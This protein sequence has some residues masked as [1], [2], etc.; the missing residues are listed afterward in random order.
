MTKYDEI[1]TICCNPTD[2]TIALIQGVDTDLGLWRQ[3]LLDVL[4]LEHR[5]RRDVIP[6]VHVGLKTAPD[7][8]P[9]TQPVKL[10]TVL[11][12]G[13]LEQLLDEGVE[14]LGIDDGGDGEGGV[15]DAEA[16]ELGAEPD[17]ELFVR[18]IVL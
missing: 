6:L 15:G 18:V 4:Q 16:L 10:K 5:L 8:L 2:C 17:L 1:F 9:E 13:L 7:N 14:A 3:P 11:D 12:V